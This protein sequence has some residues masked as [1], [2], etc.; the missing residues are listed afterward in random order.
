MGVRLGDV[1][2]TMNPLMGEETL[3]GKGKA[4]VVKPW[5]QCLFKVTEGYV[6][7]TNMRWTVGINKTIWTMNFNNL[8][9]PPIDRRSMRYVEA[10][11]VAK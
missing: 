10:L 1:R 6:E 7:M 4:K 2:I 9:I 11:A 5:S 8:C 3:G